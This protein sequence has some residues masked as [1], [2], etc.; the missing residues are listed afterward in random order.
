M[1]REQHYAEAER[2]LGL[3]RKPVLEGAP[4]G[5][6]THQAVVQLAQLHATL[7]LYNPPVSVEPYAVYRRP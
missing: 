6:N 2:L 1:T 4:I 7:A 3:A 5:F